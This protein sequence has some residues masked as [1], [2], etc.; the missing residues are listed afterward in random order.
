MAHRPSR[1]GRGLGLLHPGPADLGRP[2]QRPSR[3]RHVAAHR[4]ARPQRRVL[5][6]PAGSDLTLESSAG[7]KLALVT[8]GTRGLGAAS[9]IALAARGYRVIVADVAALANT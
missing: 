9:A 6:I 7:R 2:V 8:G 4:Q 1:P 5:S 3:S